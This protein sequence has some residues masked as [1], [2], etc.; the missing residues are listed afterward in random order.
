M[1]NINSQ[2]LVQSVLILYRALQIMA[3][4]LILWLIIVLLD[5]RRGKLRPKATINSR[6]GKKS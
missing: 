1:V 5:D 2:V 6:K 3:M 4:S